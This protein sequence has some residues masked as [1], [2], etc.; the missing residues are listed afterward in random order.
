VRSRK[1][2]REMN[3]LK[4]INKLLENGKKQQHQKKPLNTT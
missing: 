4:N 2:K 3:G 1:R